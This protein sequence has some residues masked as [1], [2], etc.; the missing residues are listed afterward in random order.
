MTQKIFADQFVCYSLCDILVITRCGGNEVEREGG[1]QR[2]NKY[3]YNINISPMA[4]QLAMQ[5]SYNR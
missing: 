3:K 2:I 5:C 4:M 1:R